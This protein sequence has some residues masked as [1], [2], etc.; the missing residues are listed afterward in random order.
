MTGL[1]KYGILRPA[2]SPR[3]PTLRVSFRTSIGIHRTQVQAFG[4]GSVKFFILPGEMFHRFATKVRAA[5]PEANCLF[6]TLSDGWNGY[7]PTPELVDMYEDL[8]NKIFEIKLCHG[9]QLER[10]AGDIIAD[11]AIELAKNCF[12][13]K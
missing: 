13:L 10:N 4:I 5:L 2:T 9:S 6:S 8:Y 3:S 7:I 1:R 11:A 12:C